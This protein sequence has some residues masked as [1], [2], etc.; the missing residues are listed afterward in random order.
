MKTLKMTFAALA[1]VLI[2]LSGCN[3][4]LVDFTVISTKNVNLDIDRSQGKQTKGK[5]SYIFGIGWNLKDAVDNALANAGKNYDMLVDGVVRYA[6]YPFVSV[7]KVEGL[8][9]STKQ[10][11]SELGEEGYQEWLRCHLVVDPQNP[12]SVEI[13]EEN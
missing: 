3:I 8:A 6:N 9:V 4:R 10:L 5:K 1:V 11:R 12:G 13:I 7:V 2:T